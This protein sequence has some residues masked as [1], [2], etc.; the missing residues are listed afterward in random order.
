MQTNKINTTN[1]T[2]KINFSNATMPI[3]SFKKN[4]N[5]PVFNAG[6][7]VK[8]DEIVEFHRSLEKSKDRDDISYGFYTTPQDV[9][10]GLPVLALPIARTDDR[11]KAEMLK[12]IKRLLSSES[13]LSPDE[14]KMLRY[15][16][17]N[18]SEIKCF[19][20]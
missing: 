17:Q 2:S 13:K 19:R 5:I 14:R 7:T 1:F 20:G 8:Y 18:E 3:N 4:V 6:K 16:Y 12:E 9:G 11:T 10:S 15:L